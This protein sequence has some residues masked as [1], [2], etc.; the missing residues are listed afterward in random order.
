MIKHCSS[1][2]SQTAIARIANANRSDV[3]NYIA[4]RLHFVTLEKQVRIKAAISGLS[5]TRLI[6]LHFETGET[7][8]Q[9]QAVR[10]YSCYRLGARVFELNRRYERDRSGKRI[11]N[12]QTETGMGVHAIYKLFTEEK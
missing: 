9:A 12:I 10:E 5:Q 4:G 3:S 8:T 6:E 1:D 7:L 11:E 2:L